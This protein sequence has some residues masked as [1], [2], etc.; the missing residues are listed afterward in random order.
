MCIVSFRGVE[1][2]DS[3]IKDKRKS[4]GTELKEYVGKYG[5]K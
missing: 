1:I 3:E 5:E 2:V 4:K